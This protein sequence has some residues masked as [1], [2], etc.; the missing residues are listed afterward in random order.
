MLTKNEFDIID[1]MIIS[2]SRVTSQM[3][4]H[5]QERRRGVKIARGSSNRT[6]SRMRDAGLL[7][8]LQYNEHDTCYY[9]LTEDACKY[10]HEALGEDY[11]EYRHL[12]K[13]RLDQAQR[14]A[15]A[16]SDDAPVRKPI[17]VPQSV[18]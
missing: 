3:L 6:L 8:M 1:Y 5:W 11:G 2:R 18:A 9:E 16:C 12:Y 17:L 4:H 15:R 14:D 7:V 10:W 13:A